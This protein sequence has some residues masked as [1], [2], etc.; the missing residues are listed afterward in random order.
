MSA[1]FVGLLAVPLTGTSALVVVGAAMA[2]FGAGAAFLASA[3]GALVGDLGRTSS[4]VAVFQMASDLGAICGPLAAG[5][6]ADGSRY[7]L[8]FGVSA[9]VVAASG[10]VALRMPATAPGLTGARP[11]PLGGPDPTRGTGGR[12]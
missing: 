2:G 3:P 7:P 8:A 12:V 11:A 6:L 1:A 9:A 5:A 10:V 4:R